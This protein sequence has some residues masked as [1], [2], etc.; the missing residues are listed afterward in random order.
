MAENGQMGG[1]VPILGQAKVLIGA[2]F[3]AIARKLNDV[4]G[5]YSKKIVRTPDGRQVPVL[6]RGDYVDAEELVEMIRLVVREELRA[7]L[8]KSET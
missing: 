6:E 8:V 2:Q 3:G 1:S 5:V 7:A 4:G